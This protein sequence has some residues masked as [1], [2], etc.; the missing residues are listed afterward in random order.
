M[1]YVMWHCYQV[2][3]R[4][5][6]ISNTLLLQFQSVKGKES[7]KP[8]F[9]CKWTFSRVECTVHVFKIFQM[10]FVK[11]SLD[12]TSKDMKSFLTLQYEWLRV[13]NSTM[14]Y[15][16]LVFIWR[17]DAPIW[18]IIIKYRRTLKSWLEGWYY[19][20]ADNERGDMKC[21]LAKGH[22]FTSSP[23]VF[24]VNKNIIRPY[25]G[26]YCV[27]SILNGTYVVILKWFI[28]IFKPTLTNA[29][30]VHRNSYCEIVLWNIIIPLNVQR[31]HITFINK[32]LTWLK[33]FLLIIKLRK[34]IFHILRL[35]W[36]WI[37]SLLK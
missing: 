14:H 2:D 20:H 34:D 1:W 3:F 5:S 4:N 30:R 10:F 29:T 11:E 36:K 26:E 6:C 33:F 17:R 23:S 15:L 21:Y 28:D 32:F 25:S 13:S 27:G 18:G 7:E 37:Y 16:V 24:T 22:N 19:S 31:Y 12:W 8:I 9:L 35:L